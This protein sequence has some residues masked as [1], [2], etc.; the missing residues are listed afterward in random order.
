MPLS[1]VSAQVTRLGQVMLTASERICVN[2]VAPTSL[3]ESDIGTVDGGHRGRKDRKVAV[4]L[5]VAWRL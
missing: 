3:P 2:A 5:P 1:A 4:G